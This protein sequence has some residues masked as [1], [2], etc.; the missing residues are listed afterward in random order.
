M[1]IDIKS[2]KQSKRDGREKV[3]KF[4][5]FAAQFIATTAE[6]LL[7][8]DMGCCHAFPF[9]IIA[10]LTG[11]TNK[12][13]LNETLSVTAVE[14]SWLA[15]IGFVFEICGSIFSALI[16]DA[17][18]RKFAMMIVNVPL[19]IAWFMM[20]TASNT[21]HI[22]IASILLGLGAGLM[23]S[24]IIT[25]VGE[26]CEP[27]F[28]G[29]MVAYTHVGW[30]LG[31]ILVATL[32]TLMPWRMVGLVCMIV[33]IFT[34]IALS[35][36]PETPLWL[37]SRNRQED[38]LKS[39]RWLR[40]WVHKESVNQEFQEL[41][42]Y[43]E[44][45]KSCEVCIKKDLKCSHPLPTFYERLQ[46]LKRKPTLKPFTIV[47]ILFVISSF[48]S[49]FSMSSYIVQILKAYN[50][51]MEP[52]QAAAVL[53]YVNNLGNISF[54]CLIRFTGKRYLYLTMMTLLLLSAVTLCAYGFLILPNGYTSFPDLTPNFALENKTLGYIP[55][56]CI[57]VTNFCMYCGINAMPWQMISEVFPY[58]TRGMATGL[59]AALSYVLSF[60]STKTFYSLDTTLSMPGVALFNCIMIVFGLISMYKILPETENRTLE[61]IEMHFADNSK[62]IT[63][64]KIDQMYPDANVKESNEMPTRSSSIVG[65]DEQFKPNN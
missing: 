32:N 20:Y 36:V 51:P 55:F 40:G 41:Q 18:G 25:Y 17:L 49:T 28:R 13:N 59:T 62:K 47:M 12:H 58:K 24:P 30:S 9:L 60:V 7:L 10:A 3:D 50:V 35:I 64:R 5:R 11:L 46:E 2:E 53:S 44:R 4:R 31:M 63:D 42:R 6:N 27:T 33:P 16:T 21:F 34:T 15:S 56:F 26:I 43:S 29:V 65:I 39:L 23:E 54:L 61:D 14:A 37:L 38:A 52:D 48:V 1:S 8:F 57:I 19:V 45:Y 22:F